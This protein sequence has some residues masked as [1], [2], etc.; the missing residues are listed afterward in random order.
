[1]DQNCGKGGRGWVTSRGCSKGK[2][3][4]CHGPAV[5]Y[6]ALDIIRLVPVEWEGYRGVSR[7]SG[8]QI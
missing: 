1:M 5:R 2:G 6:R 3:W 8:E 4:W 7:G